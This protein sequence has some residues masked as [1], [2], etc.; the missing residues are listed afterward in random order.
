MKWL[1]A[2]LVVS[3]L[4]FNFSGCTRGGGSASS[5]EG[6]LDQYVHA[7]FNAKKVDDSQNMLDLST[8]EAHEWLAS[9]S[10]EAF[11][12][13]FID[14]HMQLVNFNVKDKAKEA[15]GDVSLVYELT[16]KDGAA[17]GN[18]TER[19]EYS[20]KKIAYLTKEKEG[21]SWKIRATKNVK[22]FIERKDDLQVSP[23][24]SGA[25]EKEPAASNKK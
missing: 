1:N 22:T 2:A 24:P 18:P 23:I 15:N 25:D 14:N 20:L 8:G 3:L 11:Q 12:K 10:K 19:A 16:F 13:Q 7:A 5:P 9:M 21:G 6:A 17:A 4:A